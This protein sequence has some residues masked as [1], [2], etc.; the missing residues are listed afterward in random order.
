MPM[1]NDMSQ[2]RFAQSVNEPYS[3]PRAAASSGI[4]TDP[5]LRI[6]HALEYIAAQLGEINAKISRMTGEVKLSEF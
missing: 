4:E 2:E 6:A 5:G 3:P 1:L